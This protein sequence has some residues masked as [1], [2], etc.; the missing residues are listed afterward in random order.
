ML[1]KEMEQLKT[2]ERQKIAQ[3]IQTAKEL[4]DLSENAEYSEAKEQQALNEN[5]LAE[6]EDIIKN[7]EVIE[8]TKASQGKIC[9]GSTVTVNNGKEDRVLIIVGSNEADPLSGKISNESPLAMSFMG[10]R[11][12][13]RVSVE[14]P[15]GT[16]EYEIKDVK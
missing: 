1:Q 3:R 5:R 16:I 13:E 11:V 9:I 6:I 7:S 14:T 10:R 12:G 2:V 8:S 15:R 4:G